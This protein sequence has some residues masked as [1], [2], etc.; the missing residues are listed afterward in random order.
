MRPSL[1]GI[2]IPE[3]CAAAVSSPRFG[4]FEVDGKDATGMEALFFRTDVSENLSPGARNY[5]RT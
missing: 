1:A 3:S 4:G 5:S 2:M